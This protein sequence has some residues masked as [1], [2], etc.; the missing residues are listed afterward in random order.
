MIRF[1]AV[2]PS[3][4]STGWATITPDPLGDDQ[5]LHGI[6]ETTGRAGTPNLRGPARLAYIA[7]TIV[8]LATDHHAN[9]IALEGYSYASPN[10]AH[11]IGELGGAIRLLLHHRRIPLL[12]IAPKTL[13]LWATGAGNADKHR[14]TEAARDLAGYRGRQPDEADAIL[15]HALVADATGLPYAEP[16]HGRRDEALAPVVTALTKID[17]TGTDQLQEQ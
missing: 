14:M 8:A 16:S 2:D 6:I 15:L 9:F 3:L 11:Q 4:R 7:A 10:R 13:K 17:L 12:E 5:Q 1:L